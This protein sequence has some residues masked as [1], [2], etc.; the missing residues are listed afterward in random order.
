MD[1]LSVMSCADIIV[2]GTGRSNQFRSHRK[3]RAYAARTGRNAARKKYQTDK[4]S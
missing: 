2:S 3:R 4:S 1:R